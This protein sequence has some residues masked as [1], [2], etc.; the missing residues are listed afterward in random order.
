V[1]GN[2]FLFY[3]VLVF[4]CFVG[5]TALGDEIG[6]IEG[7]FPTGDALSVGT[8]DHAWLAVFETVGFWVA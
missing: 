7:R 4:V 3:Q 6:S 1:T 5:F 8:L 2:A